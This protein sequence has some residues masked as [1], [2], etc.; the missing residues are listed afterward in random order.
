MEYIRN[1]KPSQFKLL[2]HAA[3]QLAG[4]KAKR[5]TYNYQLTRAQQHRSRESPYKDI[6]DSSQR[7]LVRYLAE[8]AHHNGHLYE[9]ITDSVEL[10]H[11]HVKKAGDV[12]GA[13]GGSFLGKMHGT[14]RNLAET[15]RVNLDV[16]ADDFV[17]RIGLSSRRKYVSGV[18]HDDFRQHARLHQDAYLSVHERKGTANYEYL[19]DDSGDK[20]AVYKNRDTG[21]V[22]FALRGTKPDKALLNNDLVED[23]QIATGKAGETEQYET[24]VNKI[25]SLIKQHGAGNVSLSGYSKGGAEAV[26]LTQDDRLRSH[27]GQTMAIAPGA[28]PLD[29]QL[30]QKA[31]DHKIS[32]LY[33]HNDAVANSNLE[34][35]GANHHVLYN[36]SDPLRSHLLLDRLAEPSVKVV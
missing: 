24:Y 1:L 28:S 13:V 15:A 7:D 22:V 4:R 12:G 9:A 14:L 16:A 6:A 11:R 34:H 19:Q 18:V 29:D 26:H 36:E 27:L 17:H 33:H 35:S 20:H 31:R 2:R 3:S 32:Y 25:Q 21:K 10:M 5:H 8:D 23:L 30:E